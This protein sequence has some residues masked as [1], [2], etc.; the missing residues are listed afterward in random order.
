[1]THETT[2][3]SVR[4]QA[5]NA[6][7]VEMTTRKAPGARGRLVRLVRLLALACIIFL[8][9]SCAVDRILFQPPAASYADSETILKV[10][11]VDGLF[12]SAIYLPNPDARFTL[13]CSHGNAED[14]GQTRDSLMEMRDHGD[15]LGQPPSGRRPC[16][17]EHIRIG[18]PRCHELAFARGPVPQ[19][20][21]YRPGLLPHAHHARHG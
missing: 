9:G 21:S 15:P 6:V 20:R 12:I 4:T 19:H 11:T 7:P 17:G 13:L 3:T 14:I 10:P 2:S 8:L 16:P 1:M 18:S 5:Q